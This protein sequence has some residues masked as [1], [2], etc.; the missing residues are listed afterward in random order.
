MHQLSRLSLL[1]SPPRCRLTLMTSPPW[2]YQTLPSRSAEPAGVSIRGITRPPSIATES[3]ATVHC[4]STAILA[5]PLFQTA[6]ARPARRGHKKQPKLNERER[7]G[8]VKSNR[9]K[10]LSNSE[11]KPRRNLPF[12]QLPKRS[13]AKMAGCG[14]LTTPTKS[15][16]T[17][18][19]ATDRW[20]STVK[21]VR[22]F[23]PNQSALH[24]SNEP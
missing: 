7:R 17:T 16:M 12:R 1:N 19:T 20:S 8:D 4:S 18:S 22:R 5:K 3:T 14:H 6:Y 9:K 10:R 23:N 13:A 2:P 11:F 15:I 21:L 24:V